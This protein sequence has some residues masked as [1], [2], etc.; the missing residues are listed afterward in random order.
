M[1][2]DTSCWVSC[3]GLASH[4]GG[5]CDALSHFM[6]KKP[7]LSAGLDEPYWLINPVDW[8]QDLTFTFN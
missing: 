7:E 6:L 1:L 2:L 3:D 8:I 4:P 5:N